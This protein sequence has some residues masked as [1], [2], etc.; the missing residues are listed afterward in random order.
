MRSLVVCS[1][2][3][4]LPAFADDAEALHR[5]AMAKLTN[6]DPADDAQGF[7]ELTRAANAGLA[8]AEYDLAVCYERG[9][10]TRADPAAEALWLERAAQQGHV[11]AAYK[12]GHAY[13]TGRGVPVDLARA[14]RWY[15][16]AADAG[17]VE[18]QNNVATAYRN[19]D[20]VARSVDK[21]VSWYQRAGA[22]G[23]PEALANLVRLYVDARD[24][25]SAER[26]M[27]VVWRD[28]DRYAPPAQQ[29]M[30]RLRRQIEQKLTPAER[31]AAEA[32]A[33]RWLHDHPPR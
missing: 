7:A 6:A 4:A 20:G 18:A 10:G 21:A 8:S 30:D 15:L 19:G 23:D 13:R 24:W 22:G 33:Q 2:F 11:D 26:W 16:K 14:F 5:A 32:Q 28:R 25:P 9:I 29:E 31:R 1:L 3:L 12:L 17:D 27:L